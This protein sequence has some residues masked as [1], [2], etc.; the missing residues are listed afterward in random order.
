MLH[1]VIS[2]ITTTVAWIRI[3]SYT[4][5]KAFQQALRGN[6]HVYV[7]IW[8]SLI[9]F[10]LGYHLS[11]CF[12]ASYMCAMW[13]GFDG[14]KLIWIRILLLVF[15]WQRTLEKYLSFML[16]LITERFS[17]VLMYFSEACILLWAWTQK[18]KFFSEI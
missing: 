16:L 1:F 5:L 15:H 17:I 6:M 9:C 8:L 10:I 14:T 13:I 4:G 12:H 3:F 11:D 18:L 7:V 2:F